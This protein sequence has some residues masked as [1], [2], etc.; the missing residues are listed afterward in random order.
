MGLSR[1]FRIQGRSRRADD[2][3]RRGFAGFRKQYGNFHGDTAGGIE[4]MLPVILSDVCCCVFISFMLLRK[5]M[6]QAGWVKLIGG[7]V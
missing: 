3:A 7:M 4:Y 6:R 1:E 5:A 2:T